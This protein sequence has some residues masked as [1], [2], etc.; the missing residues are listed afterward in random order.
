[1]RKFNLHF[2]W[3]I[4]GMLWFVAGC[5]SSSNHR[6]SDESISAVTS[7]PREDRTE[8]GALMEQLK[9]LE[10]SDVP[11]HQSLAVKNIASRIKLSDMPAKDKVEIIAQAL[12]HIERPE[13]KRIMLS[14]LGTIRDIESLK[15]VNKYIS[16]ESVQQDAILAEW[17]MACPI[18]ENDKGLDTYEAATY[19]K[20]AAIL[21]QDMA[22]KEKLYAHIRSIPEPQAYHKSVP[23]GFTKLFNGKDLTNWKGLLAHPYNNPY[24]RAKLTPERLAAE[25]AKADALM[26][27]HWKIV[28][29][30]F[31]FDGLGYSLATLKEYEDFELW[32]DWKICYSHGDS[33]IYLRGSP[34]VQIWDPEQW[35]IGSGGLYNNRK[36]P[37]KP[38]EIADNRIG[39]WNTFYIKMIGQRVTVR[40]NGLLIVDNVVLENYWD[41]RQPILSSGQIELQCHGDPMHFNN[42]FIREIPR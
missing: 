4:V 24:E 19:L 42:I 30:I 15:A 28:E 20:R 16:D 14:A 31:Q 25:Q 22:L 39:Y 29:G 3:F 6:K 21:A 12:E 10:S 7:K 32:V 40:L 2:A 38:K 13:E 27:K 35:K 5:A 11:A 23:E 36:N 26:R 8:A 33:G 9:I 34:Q 37:S 41:Y 1:M 18:D 17:Q